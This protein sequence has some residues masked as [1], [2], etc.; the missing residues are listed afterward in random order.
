MSLPH[1]QPGLWEKPKGRLVTINR[2]W[3][4]I[5]W[6][7]W[8][9]PVHHLDWRESECR[10]EETDDPYE[11]IVTDTGGGNARPVRPMAQ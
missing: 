10:V 11:I 6:R 5:R 1:E 9:Y 7:G 3:R 8:Y 2:R 4:V